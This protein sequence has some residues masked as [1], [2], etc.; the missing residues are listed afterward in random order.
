MSRNMISKRQISYKRRE[1]L[2]GLSMGGSALAMAP[3]LES[4]RV[5]AAGDADALPKRFVF[6]VKSSGP[7][8]FNMVLEGLVNNFVDETNGEKLGNRSRR[9]AHWWMF[10]W[11]NI[12]CLRNWTLS[13][14]FKERLTIIQSLSPVLEVITPRAL[15]LSLS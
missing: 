4:M 2:H 6:V 11:R 12:N 7:D 5:H 14:K 3:F 13:K 1:F 8:K 15:G 9:K 10:R